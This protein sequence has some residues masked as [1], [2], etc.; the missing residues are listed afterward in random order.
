MQYLRRTPEVLHLR[1][2]Y[3]L[4]ERAAVG[5]GDARSGSAGARGSGARAWVAVAELEW[6]A[7]DDPAA[8]L[9]KLRQLQASVRNDQPKARAWPHPPQSVIPRRRGARGWR[10]CTARGGRR[11]WHA[12]QQ[13]TERAARGAHTAALGA[14][15]LA[16]RS[17]SFARSAHSYGARAAQLCPPRAVTPPRSRRPFS[18]ASCARRA[19]RAR[20][21]RRC[22]CT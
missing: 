7:A 11:S 19:A 9:R 2:G 8:A 5:S 12:A 4:P 14:H 6:S 3:G 10:G 18:C 15:T 17:H 1:V 20:R 21:M 13:R 22:L 16:P